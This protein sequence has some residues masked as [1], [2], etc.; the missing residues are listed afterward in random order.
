ML[1]P[2]HGD[3]HDPRRRLHARLRLL[4]RGARQPATLDLAEPARVADA[5]APMDLKY[6]VITS[7]D[8]DDLADGGAGIF[9]ETIRAHSRVD[10]GAAGSRC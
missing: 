9:A 6:V 4:R 1:A 7:V 3:V 5:V 8:R 2:R 10:A